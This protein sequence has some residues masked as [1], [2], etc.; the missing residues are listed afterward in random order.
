MIA[1]RIAIVLL[2]I[3][4][5]FASP[6]SP[7]LTNQSPYEGQVVSSPESL[8]G[9]WEA[10][11]GHGGLVGLHLKLI[12]RIPG[13]TTSVNGIRQTWE[14]LE[15]GVF[16]SKSPALQ[17]G[18]ANYFTDSPEGV[19]VRFDKNQLS[20]HL[21][22]STP[23]TPSIDLDLT[24]VS[25]VWK[26]HFHR[27]NFDSIV[28]LHRPGA[29]VATWTEDSPAGRS[30]VHIPDFP[31]VEFNGWS[32]NIPTPGNLRYAN[33]IPRP[34]TT[35]VTYG[36]LA[37]IRHLGNHQISIE[38]NAYTAI[39]CSH[40]FVGTITADHMH[41][42]GSW[43]AGPNQSPHSVSFRKAPANSCLAARGIPHR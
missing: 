10:S 35:D 39:C 42:N 17:I 18:D 1:E 25:D 15:V 27:G 29:S 11:D 38:F 32:D 26:G 7:N 20:L 5:P 34:S 2:S 40:S 21:A 31:A 24:L 8:S 12:T 33:N 43:P 19:H 14:H 4:A 23:V 28:E 41:L 6:Q 16:E 13:G 36:D 22:N 37:N 30:C 9:L 3:A